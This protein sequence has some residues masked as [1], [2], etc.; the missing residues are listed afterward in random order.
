MAHDFIWIFNVIYRLYGTFFNDHQYSFKPNYCECYCCLHA[1]CNWFR[2]NIIILI[3]FNSTIKIGRIYLAEI[4]IKQ[5][6]WYDLLVWFEL[7]FTY[8]L[9]RIVFQTSCKDFIFLNLK[10]KMEKNWIDFIEFCYSSQQFIQP[11]NYYFNRTKALLTK[12]I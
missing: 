3:K 12:S 11:C 1:K 5:K 2:F 9:N 6:I 4:L 7:Y 8:L 10:S